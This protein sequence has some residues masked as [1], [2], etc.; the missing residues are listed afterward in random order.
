MSKVVELKEQAE[1]F[2]TEI[3]EAFPEQDEKRAA[4]ILNVEKR[5]SEREQLLEALA[6][7]EI[8]VEEEQAAKELVEL[9]KQ[10]NG[11]LAEVKGFI[12]TDIRQLKNKNKTFVNTKIHMLVQLPK[13]YFSTNG[14]NGG[15]TLSRLCLGYFFVEEM[16]DK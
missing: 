2:F 10:I 5:L 7:Y 8:K 1:L 13:E 14:N 12:Q 3:N 9:D 15:N 4:F 6:D 11:R 16:V